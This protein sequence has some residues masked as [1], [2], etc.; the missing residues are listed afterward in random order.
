[1]AIQMRRGVYSKLDPKRMVS[2]EF[3]VVQ[4]GDPSYSNGQS[5]VVCFSP[6]QV[7]HLATNEDLATAIANAEPAAGQKVA[8]QAAE[9]MDA[10][11]NTAVSSCNTATTDANAA[12]S[13]ANSAA[14]SATSAASAAN[15][16]VQ[17]VTATAPISAATTGTS[18][19]I[20]HAAS[21]V[22]AGG[23]GPTADSAPA[24][25]GTITVPRVT[26]DAAGHV[27]AAAAYAAT[28]PSADASATG[29]GLMSAADKAKLDGIASG[30]DVS[31]VRS[32]QGRTGAVTVTKA[33]VGLGLVDNTSDSS[34]SV[35]SAA[36]LTTAR[37]IMLSGAV[38]G[39]ASFDGSKS[40]TITT[41]GREA[42]ASFLAAHPVGC[43]FE[44]SDG[45]YDPSANGGTWEQ[46]PSLGAY[47]WHRTA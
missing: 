12:A 38:T 11:V 14:S 4:S 28:L 16:A 2:G 46:A 33:D 32:V 8:E 45:S 36:K 44:T 40:I 31:P 42:A 5:A 22:T 47:K 23:Y 6:G 7:K 26:V 19:A 27:T 37:T 25:G 30:A 1:M 3:A 34:K 20:T 43:Y 9:A 17:E 18:V 21:G 29:H 13:R 35:A 41:T 24:W 10:K 39:S 15:T